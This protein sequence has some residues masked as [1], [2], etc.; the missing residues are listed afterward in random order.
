MT[1][2]VISC[3]YERPVAFSMTIPA[4][5]KLVFEYTGAVSGSGSGGYFSAI[6]TSSSGVW[7]SYRCSGKPG[8]AASWMNAG[9]S[10]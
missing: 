8:P 9:S 10:V 6:A 1:R 2:R 7:V 4:M 5:T 3:A